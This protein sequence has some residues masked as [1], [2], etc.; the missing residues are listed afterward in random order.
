MDSPAST[1]E[2]R[3]QLGGTSFP[4]LQKVDGSPEMSRRDQGTG[5][6]SCMPEDKMSIR[7]KYELDAS[8]SI[9]LEEEEEE[10]DK[11]TAWILSFDTMR[12]QDKDAANLLM[13]CAFLDARDLW[14]NLF[15][16]LLRREVVNKVPRWYIRCL[17]KKQTFRNCVKRFRAHD[18]I[19][20]GSRLTIFSMQSSHQ[21]WCARQS[22]CDRSM[23][24]WLAAMVVAS[25]APGG[26][27][28][29]TE[30]LEQRLLPHCG[31]VCATLLS[32]CQ[33]ATECDQEL[34][35]Y[36]IASNR[37][38]QLYYNQDT[39]KFE[40][41]ESLLHRALEDMDKLG[42]REKASGL[43]TDATLNALRVLGNVYL[44]QGKL[45]DAERVFQQ[46]LA[47][48]ESSD[49]DSALE[50]TTRLGNLYARRGDWKR[51]EDTHQQALAGKERILG[52]EHWSTLETVHNIGNMYMDQDNF[53]G[54]EKLYLRA[55]AGLEK[56]LGPQH[57]RAANARRNLGTLYKDQGRIPEA[58]DVYLRALSGYEQTY[59][60]E[61]EDIL[62]LKCDLG[63][64]YSDDPLRFEEA[65][66][67]Y[68]ASMT[69]FDNKCG[70][71]TPCSSNVRLNL[72]VLY[73]KWGRETDAEKSYM[74]A[75]SGYEELGNR[76]GIIDSSRA[77]AQ[78]FAKDPLRIKEAAGMYQKALTQYEQLH[79]S[80]SIAAVR[81]KYDL[82]SLIYENAA[83]HSRAEEL[84]VSVL[85]GF[86][87]Y[88]PS[89]DN[90]FICHTKF[91]LGYIYQD[92]P[93]R[94]QEAEAMYL[95]AL[96]GYQEAFGREHEDVLAMYNN[97]GLMYRR[98]TMIEK[99]IERFESAVEGYTSMFG[100]ED[101]KT[102]DSWIELEKCREHLLSVQEH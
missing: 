31:R 81:T 69:G 46:H 80:E 73:R 5:E 93:A 2:A 29:D 4:M 9:S 22:G 8:T 1:N 32:R 67:M 16:P 56:A 17:S 39:A 100:A 74:A 58:E 41:A 47:G 66:T 88:H 3:S 90:K 71:R 98:E 27:S 18:L 21:D 61:D 34:V 7:L 45:D 72:G 36:S 79:E 52:A 42:V 50:I 82:G 99:A 92:D 35:S 51:S 55:S 40:D 63:N 64:L 33:D 19:D 68:L 38:G 12:S 6:D 53:E 83:E 25:A 78:I 70:H 24:E 85:D 28:L 97:L 96:A 75:L 91:S 43:G 37:I 101:E 26:T 14:Y 11:S 49:S 10:G 15:V 86:Q 54:A 44:D 13:L 87:K 95:E 102:L 62:S 94:F 76:H 65:E 84:F 77:L 30:R 57:R 60:P 59:A 20:A 48:L 23:F 89:G